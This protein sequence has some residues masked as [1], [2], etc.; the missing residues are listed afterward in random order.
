MPA[1]VYSVSDFVANTLIKS[2]DVNSRFTDIK[3]LLNTTGLDDTNLANAGITRATKLKTG[4]ASHVIINDGTGAMSSEAALLP[5]RGGTGLSSPTAGSLLVTNGASAMTALAAAT[6]GRGILDTGTSWASYVVDTSDYLANYSLA[7]TVGSSALTIALKDKAGSD[8]SSTSPVRIGFR[9]STLTSGT[10]L[11]RTVTAALSVVV[12]SGSTLGSTSANPNWVYVYAID[13][14]GTVELAV[15]GSRIP[16]EGSLV[17][18]TAE[19]GAGAAD[20]KLVVYSTAA[21][22]SVPVRLL[23]R[24]KSTQATAGTWATA[25]AEISLVPFDSLGVDNACYMSGANARGSG[26]TLVVRFANAPVVSG[27]TNTYTATQSSTNGDSITINRDGV[28]KVSTSFTV[29]AA[30]GWQLSLNSATG[31]IGDPTIDL[32]T[33]TQSASGYKGVISD[34]R[35]FPAGSVFRLISLDASSPSAGYIHVSRLY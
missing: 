17:T 23:G 27:D 29:Q 26:S 11:Q 35:F 10:Y 1:L 21:R 9:N 22:T 20:S 6:A 24:V 14:A 7:A 4:T 33:L 8:P 19:G 30:T 18:T 2:A 25:P 3:T 5:V 13:N 12:S 15:S 16:D 31:S 34:T 32:G 28:Y